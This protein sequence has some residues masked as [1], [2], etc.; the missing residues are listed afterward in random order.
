MTEVDEEMP[1]RWT[2]GSRCGNCTIHCHC[3]LGVPGESVGITFS[4]QRMLQST[5]LGRVIVCF[6]LF[7]ISTAGTLG[8]LC[9]LYL[10]QAFTSI[11]FC[12]LHIVVMRLGRKIESY[13]SMLGRT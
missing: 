6:V 11:Q 9:M 4:T 7:P 3:G 13:K 8:S 2:S 1:L 10:Q 12:Q 5:F